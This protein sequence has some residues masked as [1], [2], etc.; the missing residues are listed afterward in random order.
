MLRF[1]TLNNTE[2]FHEHVL[3]QGF[4]VD[5]YSANGLDSHF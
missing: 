1:I 3:P 4:I 2:I 5:F